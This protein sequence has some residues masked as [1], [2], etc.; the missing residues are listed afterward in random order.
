M[1]GRM[2]V[3]IGDSTKNEGGDVTVSKEVVEEGEDT[4][5][6]ALFHELGHGVQTEPEVPATIK[7]SL[8]T[9]QETGARYG[10]VFADAFAV[11]GLRAIGRTP[12]Q[13]RGGAEGALKNHGADADDP[14]WPLR[15]ASMQTVDPGL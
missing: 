10:E 1:M 9:T 7:A 8:L 15:L 12:Q 13:I 3:A 4:A 11:I 6:F 14:E 2:T 5:I